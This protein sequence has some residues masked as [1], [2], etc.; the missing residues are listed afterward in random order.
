MISV[1]YTMICDC[2]RKKRFN[3]GDE[4]EADLNAN[5]QFHG[6]T[7]RKAPNGATWDLCPEC[8]KIETANL[9]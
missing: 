6:W 8:S 7:F 3:N 2:C 1:S 5:A 9:P 4:S